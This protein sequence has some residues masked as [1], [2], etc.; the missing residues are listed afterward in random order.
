[1]VCV[2]DDRLAANRAL[3]EGNVELLRKELITEQ[4]RRQNVEHELAQIKL[5]VSNI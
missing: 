4:Q 3:R 1:M 2:N 5:Q